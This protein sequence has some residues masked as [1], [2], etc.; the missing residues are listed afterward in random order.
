MQK[1]TL[2]LLLL[3]GSS[4]LLHGQDA[5]ATE[6]RPYIIKQMKKRNIQGL[7]LV[8][9]DDQKILWSEGFG[10]ANV[11]EGKKADENT[12]YRVGSI[13]KVFTAMEPTR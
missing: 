1:L 2:F 4:S 6:L 11:A 8:L 12:L 13:S 3:L 10:F 7:S 9:V 5:Y